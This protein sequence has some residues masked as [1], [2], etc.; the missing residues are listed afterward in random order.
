MNF[1]FF[2]GW[3]NT[4]ICVTLRYVTGYNNIYHTDMPIWCSLGIGTAAAD[5]HRCL[6]VLFFQPFDPFECVCVCS[7]IFLRGRAVH[8][9]LSD[10]QVMQNE[11]LIELISNLTSGKDG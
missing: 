11:F 4:H 9:W 1:G 3:L 7:H 5:V 2:G 6:P 10:S 8:G